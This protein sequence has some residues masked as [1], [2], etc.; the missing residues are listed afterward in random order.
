MPLT[1]VNSVIAANAARK[2]RMVD[3]IIEAAGGSVNGKTIALLGLTFKPQTDDM[4]DAP[5]LV[6]VPA[7]QAA[8]ATIRAYDPEGMGQAAQHLTGLTFGTG[9]WQT[10]EGADLAVIV[11]EW[12]AFRALDLNRMAATLSDRLLVDL[13]NVYSATEARQAGLTYRSIGRPEPAA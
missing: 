13:R 4:R 11:T 2:E 9:P 12:N 5:S 1:I 7:L 10:M 6:I 3:I 8:G